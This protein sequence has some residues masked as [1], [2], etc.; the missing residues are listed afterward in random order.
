ML[1]FGRKF[2]VDHSTDQSIK[3]ELLVEMLTFEIKVEFIFFISRPSRNF[4]SPRLFHRFLLLLSSP[5]RRPHPQKK[6]QEEE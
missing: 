5:K 4:S 2:K 3:V 6:M 1:F